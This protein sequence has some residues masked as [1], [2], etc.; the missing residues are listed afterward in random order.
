MLDFDR[1]SVPYVHTLSVSLFLSLSV[2]G[3]CAQPGKVVDEVL[4]IK[5]HHA[6]YTCHT[7]SNSPPYKMSSNPFTGSR[8][9]YRKILLAKKAESAKKV[10]LTNR[11]RLF[12]MIKV[13]NR[14]TQHQHL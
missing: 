1:S 11:A 9:E 13:L 10:K 7:K 14:N 12:N 8:D 5:N 4:V 2:C 6:P 3:L